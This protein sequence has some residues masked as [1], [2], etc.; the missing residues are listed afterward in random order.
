[1]VGLAGLAGLAELA[2]LAGLGECWM[3][4][5]WVPK[6]LIWRPGG[7]IWVLWGAIWA[8]R[9]SPGTPHRT[10]GDPYVD[11]LSI[12][13]GFR[14]TLGSHFELILETFS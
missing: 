14:V 6:P 12:F 5:F 11:L 3:G 4:S 8:I 7:S 2:G 1:M 13:D 10:H 9:G